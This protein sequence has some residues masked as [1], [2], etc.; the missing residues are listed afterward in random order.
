MDNRNLP[1]LVIMICQIRGFWSLVDLNISFFGRG[2]QLWITYWRSKPLSR[3]AEPITRGLLLVACGFP[4]SLWHCATCSAYATARS[5]WCSYKYAMGNLCTL[6]MRVMKSVDE[7]SHYMERF[8]GLGARLVGIAIQILLY[9]DDIVLI[10]DSLE[11]LQRH[12]N[13]L[14]LFCMDKGLSINMDKTILYG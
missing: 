4:K 8:G 13:A 14:K 3:R 2:S 11:E 9:I 10:S 1:I 12:L 7:V 6:W 5:P